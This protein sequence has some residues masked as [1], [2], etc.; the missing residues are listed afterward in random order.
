MDDDIVLQ[1]SAAHDAINGSVGTDSRSY[2]RLLEIGLV[3]NIIAADDDVGIQSY[4]GI[5]IE[6]HARPGNMTNDGVMIIDSGSDELAELAMRAVPGREE[7]A[8]AVRITGGGG[9]GAALSCHNKGND[10]GIARHNGDGLGGR[11]SGHGRSLC[12]E[13]SSDKREREGTRREDPC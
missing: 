11:L 2:L 5:I 10:N 9:S 13:G 3:W 6:L 12:G 4:Q 7:I 1:H 8:G